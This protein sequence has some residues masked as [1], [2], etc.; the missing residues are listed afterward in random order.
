MSRIIFD[1]ISSACDAART[2]ADGLIDDMATVRTTLT[3]LLDDLAEQT[4]SE[5]DDPDLY[6][7]NYASS[8]LLENTIGKLSERSL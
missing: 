3:D 6:E 2:E 4:E 5:K 1:D 8:V 7:E